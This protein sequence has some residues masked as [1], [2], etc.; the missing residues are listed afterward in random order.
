MA[1]F[2]YYAGRDFAT[3]NLTCREGDLL[4]DR[5]QGSVLIKKLREQY[6]EDSVVGKAGGVS[7][8]DEQVT[9]A[10]AAAEYDEKKGKKDDGKKD[11]EKKDKKGKKD[12]KTK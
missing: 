9:P 2:M 4:P 8:K 6:G 1:K 3:K 10:Q 11:D 7:R 5:W 12:D